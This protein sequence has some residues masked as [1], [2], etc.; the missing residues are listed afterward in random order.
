[1]VAFSLLACT[2]TGDQVEITPTPALPT[3]EI[4]FPANNAQVFEGTDLT[5][6]LVA[7]D[8]DG[9]NRVEI[10]IDSLADEEPDQVVRPDSINP[11]GVFRVE[12]NWLARG[13]G[14]HQITAK[15]YRID[16]TPGDETTIVIEVVERAPDSP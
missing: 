9:I 14:R 10:F 16:G 2:L 11:V 8:A 13:V 4:L 3:V 15:A 5:I 12:T 1:M 6:D 7:R